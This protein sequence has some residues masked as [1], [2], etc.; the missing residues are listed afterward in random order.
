MYFQNGRIDEVFWENFDGISMVQ[1]FLK[2]QIL[3]NVDLPLV[4]FNEIF[5]FLVPATSKK[6]VVSIIKEK[7]NEF[8]TIPDMNSQILR[9]A[10]IM[11]LTSFYLG[12][13][14]TDLRL[15]NIFADKCVHLQNA[16]KE[17]IAF[18]PKRLARYNKSLQDAYRD[19]RLSILKE[20]FAFVYN[21]NFH[22]MFN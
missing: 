9:A 12:L 11:D 22:E 3:D 8:K 20:N 6:E 19:E 17:Q 18:T 7:L 14:N 21:S 15:V 5:S 2:Q 13:L 1:D 4:I 16:D 10:E